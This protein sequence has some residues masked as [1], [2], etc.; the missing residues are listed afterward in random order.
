MKKKLY[1]L[2]MLA[3]GLTLA[4]CNDDLG[5][6]PGNPDQQI[7]NAYVKVTLNLPT[8]TGATTRAAN[9]DYDDG[10]SNEY[11]VNKAALIFFAG[12]SETDAKATRVASLEADGWN[13]DLDDDA[14]TSFKEFVVE[15]E[16]P[17]SGQK[18]FALAVLNA[19][20]EWNN[21]NATINGKTISTLKDLMTKDDNASLSTYA[22][23][24]NGFLMLNAPLANTI[25]ANTP[26]ATI[27]A[28]D[29]TTL[30]ELTI[31]DDAN[32]AATL[33]AD[34]I[35][36]ERA[37]A[38]V[39]VAKGSKWTEETDGSYS[40]TV[41][42]GGAYANDKA[43]LKGWYLNITNKTTKLGHDIYGLTGD[44]LGTE[45]VKWASYA[46]A[47]SSNNNQR[48]YSATNPRRA[49]WGIDCNY[50]KSYSG[51]NFLTQAE[52]DFNIVGKSQ[53]YD[54]I[55]ADL[56]PSDGLLYGQEDEDGELI[57]PAVYCFENTMNYDKQA[58]IQTTG[59]VFVMQYMF[60]PTRGVETFFTLPTADKNQSTLP[61]YTME[62]VSGEST[63]LA[64][65]ANDL[66]KSS[67]VKFNVALKDGAG[68]LSSGYYRGA[69]G[70]RQI[71]TKEGG[72]ELSDE[73]AL[74]LY[75][76]IGEVALY[77]NGT[78]YYYASRIQHFGKEYC[79]IADPA[80]VEL[81]DY[82]A[83]HLGRYGVLRN[84]W[85]EIDVTGISGPGSPVPPVPTD[86]E[87][88]DDGTAGYIKA[89][90]NILSWAKR[91]QDVEL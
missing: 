35:Y 33:P 27:S 37:V 88:P 15:V 26:G 30:V 42:N 80:N 25:A 44:A 50:D 17:A 34:E 51:E 8:A 76:V 43:I 36:V 65:K 81:K 61:I 5:D 69:D 59:I 4:G 84:N 6:G 1:F 83:S 64:D 90:I 87:D 55:P 70:M 86:P 41:D 28:G 39:T 18:L 54:L 56:K 46:N 47:T 23:G 68:S 72:T 62:T 11:A 58:Q 71:F 21:T 74:Q 48:F 2:S 89:N 9:D 78:T 31:F 77:Q 16:K 14:I 7:G 73:E 38:K 53:S 60:D 45:Y 3:A 24:T 40:M 91:E 10:E 19:T 66:L 82:N 63:S 22:S 29:L 52:A 13:N 85:Y 79:N 12:T 32:D 75:D 49:Y 57:Y 67:S 20:V